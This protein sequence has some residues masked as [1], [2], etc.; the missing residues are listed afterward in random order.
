MKQVTSCVISEIT[1]PSREIVFRIAGWLDGKRIRKNCP[2]RADAEAERQILEVQRLQGEIVFALLSL[3]CPKL[4]P[5]SRGG[6]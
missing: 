5:R 2:T 6:I 3:D 1:N 4:T